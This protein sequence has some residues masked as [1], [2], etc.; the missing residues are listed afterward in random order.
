VI[1]SIAGTRVTLTV[2]LSDSFDATYLNPPGP[3]VVKYTFPGRIEQVGFESMRVTLTQLCE[4]LGEAALK[5]IGE[6]SAAQCAPAR[7]RF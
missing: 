7:G 5:S 2:P 1:K 4:R 3:S 6:A